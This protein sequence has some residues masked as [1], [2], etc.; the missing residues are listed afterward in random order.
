MPEA[1]R[2]HAPDDEFANFDDFVTLPVRISRGRIIV[3]GPMPQLQDGAV[4]EVR[5]P[6]DAISPPTS[7]FAALATPPALLPGRELLAC[8]AQVRFAIR[9]ARV[10][11][12][13]LEHTMSGPDA[14]DANGRKIAPQLWVPV[15]LSQPLHLRALRDGHETL[16]GGAC[17]I[18]AL[19]CSARSLNHANTLLSEAFEPHRLA[20]NGSV[21]RRA[22]VCIQGEWKLLDALRSHAATPRQSLPIA[23]K[24]KRDRKT[25][26]LFG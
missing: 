25:L 23:G 10:P 19:N 4:G 14:R 5:L 3:C 13:L 22:Y 18:P 9:A 16:R 1:P 2:D 6:R 12:H 15:V 7:P 20:H 8:G 24:S 11:P 21:F 17:Q 26:R